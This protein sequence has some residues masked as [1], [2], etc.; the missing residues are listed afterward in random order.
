MSRQTMDGL[1]LVPL[2][3]QLAACRNAAAALPSDHSESRM[4][5]AQTYPLVLGLDINVTDG[6]I[7][8]EVD[9]GADPKKVA[10]K[11]LA[12]RIGLRMDG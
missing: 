4:N 8:I 3:F 10:P 2:W 5:L 7:V 6:S 12:A 9:N 1:P 11:T